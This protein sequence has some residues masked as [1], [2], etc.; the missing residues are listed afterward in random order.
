MRKIVLS[1]AALAVIVSQPARAADPSPGFG[2]SL[3][4]AYGIPMG[5]ASGEAGADL[6]KIFSGSLP[7]QVDV[8]YRFT[9][10]L[11]VAA[12]YQYAFAFVASDLGSG[13]YTCSSSGV[14]CSGNDMRLGIEAFWH[15][16]PGQQLDP[17]IGLGTGYEWSKV[18]VESGGISADVKF[19]GWEFFNA[20]V[21]LDYQVAPQLGV[22]PFVQFALGQYSTAEALGT[23]GDIANKAVHEWLQIGVRGTFNL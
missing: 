1:L 7:I 18:T 6:S 8:G 14:S 4:L 12:Y 17:W 22:G 13:S 15:F 5:S 3:R 21:G 23:S 2:A 9:P 10:N 20:Q 19:H 11:S 16:M